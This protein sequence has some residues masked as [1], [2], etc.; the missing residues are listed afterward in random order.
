MKN[1]IRVNRLVVDAEK[2]VNVGDAILGAIELATYEEREVEL[3]HND[4]SFKIC[5][6]E[7]VQWIYN[8]RERRETGC[9]I[10]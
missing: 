3:I 10:D 1:A 7:L 9:P 5:P 2:G 6:G 4:R 8:N